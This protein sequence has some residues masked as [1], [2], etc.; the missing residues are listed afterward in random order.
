MSPCAL[1]VTSGHKSP[2][3]VHFYLCVLVIQLCSILCNPIRLLG[4]W[5][6]PG[7]KTGVGCHSLLQGIVP[8]W[9]SNLGLLH[10]R[11]ILYR[12]SYRDGLEQKQPVSKRHGEKSETHGSLSP[13]V[14]ILFLCSIFQNAPHFLL[15]QSFLIPPNKSIFL[16]LTLLH[17]VFLF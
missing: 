6:S 7:K 13:S 10:C 1:T 16:L 3:S 14:L 12:L 9:G 15:L 4:P 5:D 11:Q 2:T 8:T 17:F